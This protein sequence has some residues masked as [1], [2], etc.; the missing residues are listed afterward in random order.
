MLS[1]QINILQGF[2]ITRPL[3]FSDALFLFSGVLVARTAAAIQPRQVSYSGSNLQKNIHK[4]DMNEW[5]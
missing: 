3:G 1:N 5:S 4:T 2:I